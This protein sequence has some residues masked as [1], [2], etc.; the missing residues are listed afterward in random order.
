MP[1]YEITYTDDRPV[2]TIEA[3]HLDFVP[4]DADWELLPAVDTIPVVRAADEFQWGEI[5]L[6]DGSKLAA[7]EHKAGKRIVFLDRALDAD[8][9]AVWEEERH[10]VKF[11]HEL[12]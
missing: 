10:L 12:A 4:I 6:R 7:P 9:K 2:E 1:R 11:I 5:E 3:D 8:G